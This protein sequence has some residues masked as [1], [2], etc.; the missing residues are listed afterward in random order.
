M[1]K[2]IKIGS[3]DGM[4]ILIMILLKSYIFAIYKE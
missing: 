2:V 1:F 3:Q 4:S